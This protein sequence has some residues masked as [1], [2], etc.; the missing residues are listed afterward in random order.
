MACLPGLVLASVVALC[1][2]AM[3]MVVL[4]SLTAPVIAKLGVIAAVRPPA[5]PLRIRSAA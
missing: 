3:T 1:V 2:Q 5:R 4:Q